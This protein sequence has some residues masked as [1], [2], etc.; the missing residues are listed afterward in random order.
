MSC[1]N[2]NGGKDNKVKKEPMCLLLGLSES[3]MGSV[4]YVTEIKVSNI[5]NRIV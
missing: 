1:N 5:G 2:S 4:S 3:V